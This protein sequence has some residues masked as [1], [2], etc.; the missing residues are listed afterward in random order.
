M[1]QHILGDFVQFVYGKG[2]PARNRKQGSVPVYGSAGVV[3][4]HNEAIVRGPGIIVGRKGTIGAV[5]WANQDFYPIDTTYYIVIKRA[6][7]SIR[8]I[9]YLLKTLPL[10][11]MNT[12]LAVPGL[13]RS[14]A[15]RLQVSIPSPSIQSRIV[16]IL[17]AYD[18]L[19]ENNRRR[20]QLLEQSARLLYKEWF[21]HLRFPGHERATITNGVPEGWERKPLRD[22]AEIKGGKQYGKSEMDDSWKIPIFGGNGVQGYSQKRTHTGFLI[23]FGRVGANCGSIHWSYNGAWV[24]NNA[25]SVIPISHNELVL[26]HLLHYDFTHLRKGSAQPFIP[27][28]IL[29]TV[30]F[31]TPTE[32]LAANFCEVIR[33]IRYQQ[34]QIDRQIN[35]LAKSRD[36]LV[37]RLMSG[38][39]IKR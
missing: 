26:Q 5:Y 36:M 37:P 27:N 38:D 23:V 6:D 31:L 19:I 3:G 24:N 15:L 39:V 33:N 34:Q 12:D 32:S 16:S 21:V 8:Y 9:Y 1:K 13:N 35:L 2:L 20:I 25:T 18:N 29:A 28:G 17:S 22:L 7:T 11:S 10:S 30:E 14:N 4:T